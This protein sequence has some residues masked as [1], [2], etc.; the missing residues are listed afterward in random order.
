MRLWTYALLSL[1]T[2]GLLWPAPK[3]P[4]RHVLILYGSTMGYLSPCGCTSPMSGGLKRAATAIKQI[5]SSADST[6]VLTGGLVEGISRQDELKAE[7]YA[8]YSRTLQAAGLEFTASEAA[9][10]PGNLLEMDQLSGNKLVSSSVQTR[11]TP[12][13]QDAIERPPF[14]IASVSSH[15][16]TVADPIEL[17]PA[18]T[19]AVIKS[20]IKRAEAAHLLLAVLY[21]GDESGARSLAKNHPGINA[22]VYRSTSDPPSRP[23]REGDT[24]L[25][26]TGLHGK[27]VIALSYAE[28]KLSD[29]SVVSLGPE[30]KDDKEASRVYSA[31]LQRVTSE[32]LLAQVPRH[33]T[34]AYAGPET[35]QS[36]H[37]HAYSVWE[38]SGHAHA[39]KDI[40]AQE[41]GR[42]PDCVSCHVTGLSSLSGFK[43]ESATPLLASVTCESCHGPA[44]AHAASPNAVTL[45]KASAKTCVSC[46]T[47]DNSPGFDFGTYW[48][49]IKH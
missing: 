44:A 43:S 42:D 4:E 37:F 28:G 11:S 6:F 40:D 33:E 17:K 16:A 34:P 10:G 29:Y 25:V 26:T 22:L 14:L 46:H 32:D 18:E 7:T 27:N 15:P 48:D 45:P 39:L 31:Y 1:G 41:H 35:C 36:C 49:K 38:S 2:A 20:L 9:L 47:L 8:E 30:V 21:D 12:S 5:E 3:A 19:S 24:L 13:L 23:L